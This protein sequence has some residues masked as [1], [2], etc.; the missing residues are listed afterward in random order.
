M[1]LKSLAAGTLILLGLLCLLP[2]FFVIRSLGLD[3]G[4]EE[5]PTPAWASLMGAAVVTMVLGYQLIMAKPIALCVMRHRSGV[6]AWFFCF[7]VGLAAALSGIFGIYAFSQYGP[8]R[9]YVHLYAIAMA[10]GLGLYAIL[11]VV[12]GTYR[13]VLRH[14]EWPGEERIEAAE[15]ISRHGRITGGRAILADMASLVVLVV[16]LA[17]AV[18]AVYADRAAHVV[19]ANAMYDIGARY[20]LALGAGMVGLLVVFLVLRRLAEAGR[21]QKAA[22]PKRWVE[23]S[24]VAF[25]GGLY[26][27]FG[28]YVLSHGVTVA[29]A[30][31]AEGEAGTMPMTVVEVE[32]IQGRNKRC[33]AS[34]IA[35]TQGYGGP[36]GRRLC[37]LPASVHRDL[38]V[39]DTV[40]LEGAYTALGFRYDNIRR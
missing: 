24:F 34:V 19:P 10:V 39:G 3:Y 8:L 5:L 11:F 27:V 17:P 21:A 7:F 13:A 38:R 9:D 20:G 18:V 2:G 1:A 35:R 40:M 25:F 31:V 12:P 37:N 6:M 26:L 16:L 30:W 15:A 28:G 29:H 32:A 33:Y 4:F 36:T 23:V 22:P 14:R